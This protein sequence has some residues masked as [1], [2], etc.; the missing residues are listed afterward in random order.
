M[1]TTVI[2][3]PIAENTAKANKVI[4]KGAKV[5]TPEA[6]A[7]LNL[8]A[9]VAEMEQEQ[10]VKREA[11]KKQTEALKLQIA[12]EKK[13]LA[14]EKKR[15]KQDAKALKEAQKS[16]L[17]DKY[18][19]AVRIWSECYKGKFNFTTEETREFAGKIAQQFADL[20]SREPKFTEALLCAQRTIQVLAEIHKIGF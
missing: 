3:S 1:G 15:M 8:K 16:V 11:L 13:R 17:V 10:R 14:E 2:K 19:L 4:A 9:K 18:T 20:Y 6:E 5:L 7:L 12:E